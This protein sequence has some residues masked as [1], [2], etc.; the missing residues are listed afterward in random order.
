[1]SRWN[2]T[3]LFIDGFSG[4]GEYSGGERGSPLI[5]LA[6][7]AGHSHKDKM[8][9]AIHF[10]FI[11][12]QQDRADHLREL[13]DNQLLDLP[14]STEWQIV[15]NSFESAMRPVLDDLEQ[16][17]RVLPPSFVMIDPFGIKDVRM[18]TLQA[19]LQ[20]DKTEVYVSFMYSFINRFLESPEFEEHLDNLFGSP[21]WRDAPKADE[22]DESRKDF[23][24]DLF[25]RQLKGAGAKHVVHF[26]LYRNKQ[27]VYAIFFASG[28]L[29]GCDKMKGAIWSAT[30]GTPFR[31]HGEQA[32]QTMFGS[33]FTESIHLPQFAEEVRAE[34]GHREEVTI[35]E[36]TRFAMSDATIFHS[37]QLKRKTL[38]PMEERGELEVLSSPRKR[39]GAFPDGTRLRILSAS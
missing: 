37:G 32:Q 12:E 24:F 27:L 5:A 16:T 14:S 22:D 15:T 19:L 38:K 23:L 18:T 8:N 11:E 34:F 31:F 9:G 29:D 7:L 13:I 4:P 10:I 20:N 25:K 39:R 1:M 26:E 17:N 28:S 30:E 21:K 6:T 33:D 36:I 35:E 2:D 3:V